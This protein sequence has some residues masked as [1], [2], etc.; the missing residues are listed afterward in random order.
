MMYKAGKHC[1]IGENVTFGTG[2]TIGHNCIIEDN[3]VL[4]NNVCIDS[5]CIIR[6]DVNLG[7]NS[8]VGANCILGEHC[9]DYYLQQEYQS[10]PLKIGANALIRSGT[11]IYGNGMIGNDFQTGHHVTIRENVVIGDN[12]SIGTLSDVQ[13]NCQFGNYVRLH[14]NV[15]VAPLSKI[16][17]YVWIFPRVVLT[18]DP[19]PPS[20]HCIGVH[21]HSFAVVAA[22]AIILPGVNLQKDSLVAAGA[23]VTRD[24][25]EFSV[26]AGNPAKI[27]SDIREI[28]NKA[29]GELAYPWRFHFD[30]N[31]PWMNSTY[32]EWYAS[33]DI[34]D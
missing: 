20:E 4:G 5:N 8:N 29:T 2:V 30:R 14:S 15:F 19:T 6:K 24:V 23:V 32:E 7:D 34:I 17:D 13:G 28:K 33:L 3:V 1:V 22:G 18:N 27:I 12:V 31:M 25:E 21:I 26:V 9:M 10:H 11:I 16:D